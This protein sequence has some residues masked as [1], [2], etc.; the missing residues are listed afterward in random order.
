MVRYE[1]GTHFIKKR[2]NCLEYAK[3][4]YKEITEEE[5]YL[6]DIEKNKILLNTYGWSNN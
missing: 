1:V 5:K 3:R 6:L 2:F 4:F